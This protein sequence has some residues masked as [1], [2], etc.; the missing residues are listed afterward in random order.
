MTL[1]RPGATVWISTAKPSLRSHASTRAAT[2]ASVAPGS[3]GRYTLGMR[4]NSR[5][6]STSSS[7]SILARIFLSALMP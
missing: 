6:S 4:I 7:A 5:V 1:G 3:S 2:F